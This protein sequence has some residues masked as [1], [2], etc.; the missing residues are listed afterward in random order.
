MVL[1][2]YNVAGNRH[3]NNSSIFYKIKTIKGMKYR[4]AINGFLKSGK[5]VK[6]YCKNKNNKDMIEGDTY[7]NRRETLFTYTVEGDG[8][9]MEFG[10]VFTGTN[11]RSIMKVFY[12]L[13]LDDN[14]NIVN[15]GKPEKNRTSIYE[16][17]NHGFVDF[18]KNLFS[19]KKDV[20]IAID[21]K[22]DNDDNEILNIF[23]D[24][25]GK[26]IIRTDISMIEYD[27]K[28]NLYFIPHKRY[29]NILN[30]IKEDV[31][32]FKT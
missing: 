10:L 19:Q 25:Y 23:G 18:Y 16:Y 22:T 27:D 21:H 14:N 24:E 2:N 1:E 11:V 17:S 32:Y 30:V 28:R 26:F 7:V 4:F 31:Y 8:E 5:P 12:M 29:E 20:Y 6:T 15:S 9:T 13:I 3:H